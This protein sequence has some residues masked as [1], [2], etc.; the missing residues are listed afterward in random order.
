MDFSW[1]RFIGHV[2]LNYTD[3]EIGRWTF[4]YFNKM[5]QHYKDMFDIELL[6]TKSG[7]TYREN[8]YKADHRGE[9]FPD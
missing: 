8:D 4:V 5:Y 6:L 1:I 2:K 7:S 9:L 3:K